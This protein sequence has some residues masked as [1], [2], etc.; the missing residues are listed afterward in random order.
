MK[1][2]GNLNS[3]MPKD[4][5]GHYPASYGDWVPPPPAPK[6]EN[7]F[8]GAFSYIVTVQCFIFCFVFIGVKLKDNM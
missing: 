6:I 8:P 5:I 7:S 1:Y 4:G 2:V 3:R